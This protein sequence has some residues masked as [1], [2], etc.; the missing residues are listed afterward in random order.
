[1]ASSSFRFPVK[2]VFLRALGFGSVSKSPEYSEF[3][4]G[5]GPEI[6]VW[7]FM[8]GI[9]VSLSEL[10]DFVMGLLLGRAC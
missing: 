10:L 4:Y 7:D 1:M 6:E 8:T 3:L 9:C 2:I 5:D